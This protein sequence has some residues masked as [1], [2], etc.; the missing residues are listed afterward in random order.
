MIIVNLMRLARFAALTSLAALAWSASWP[1]A[2][3]AQTAIRFT[4]DRKIDGPSAPFFLALERGYFKAEGLDVTIDAAGTPPEAIDRLAS[5]EY[6]MGVA[7]SNLLIK[8]H[9]SNPDTAIKAVFAV[10]DKPPYSIIARKSRGIAAPADLAGKKLGAPA[11]D[12]AF[13]QWPI[14]ANVN[15]IDP[16]KVTIEN[17]GAPVREPM[18]AAGEV[19]AIT[20]YSFT[21]Y[22]DLVNRGVPADDLVVFLMADYDVELYGDVIA[23][24]PRL[25]VE[26]PEAVRAFLRA[27]VSALKD[28]VRDPAQAIDAVL[29]RNDGIKREVE[30]E[31]LRM[32]IRDNILTPAVKMLGYGAVD[33]ERLALAID[34]LSLTYHFKAKDKATAVFDLSFLPPA[35][36]R[37]AS[38]TAS[39]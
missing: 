31:H 4:L 20:G 1:P 3:Q 6:D 23:V 10:F 28:T 12:S 30:L 32:A 36:E 26:K 24:A 39:R 8:F 15:G 33:P 16:G 22:V 27:Y 9:D 34:Q 11:G 29:H 2:A 19:D 21:A 37:G 5:G 25:A 14:F 18:L 38:G 7:D 35:A 17:V 13:A